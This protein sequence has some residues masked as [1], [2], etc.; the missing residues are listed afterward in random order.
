MLFTGSLLP[1]GAVAQ[2]FTPPVG[3]YRGAGELACLVAPAGFNSV[4][5][6]NV[7]TES[8]SASNSHQSVFVFNGD[9]TG[10]LRSE[11]T[12]ITPPPTPGFVPSASSSESKGS[13][14]YSTGFDGKISIFVKS[15]TGKVLT[16][17]RKGQTFTTGGYALKGFSNETGNT[18]AL[19]TT[20]PAVETIT[21]SNG[22]SFP[23]ICHR[24]TA[25]QNAAS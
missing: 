14:T 19:S 18:V 9:G 5:Q 16:G 4:F 13:F 8:W 25:L 15:V 21:Y 7:P 6:P 3:T 12:G 20:A 2:G 10:T 22:Q 17:P 1:G 24:S 11:E 23:R